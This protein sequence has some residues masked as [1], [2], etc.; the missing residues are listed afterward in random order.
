MSN[1]KALV[2]FSGG[3]DSLLAARVLQEQGITVHAI[4]FRSNFF[5]EN[6]AKKAAE[7]NDIYIRDTVDISKE[8]L[9][10][11]RD[12]NVKKGKNLNPCIDC[13]GLMLRKAKEYVDTDE[14]HFLATGEVLGQRPFSQTKKAMEEVAKKAG[15][16]VLRPLSARRMDPTEIEE[17]GWVDR[18]KLLDIQGR[19]RKEQISW[20]VHYNL[21]E[22]ESPSGGCLLTEEEFSRKLA[23]MTEHFDQVRPEDA[24]LLKKG[25]VEWFNIRNKKGEESPVMAVIGRN[26]EDNVSLYYSQQ[27]GDVLVRLAEMEGPLTLLR[28]KKYN[29]RTKEDTYEVEVQHKLDIKEWKK[30]VY[31]REKEMLEHIALLDAWYKPRVRGDKTTVKVARNI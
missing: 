11:I 2:L 24:E 16:E 29:F 9:G 27:P 6:N 1:I 28:S 18:D 12:D 5:D 17:K 20:T 23:D 14:Y 3:L 19:G 7:A 8:L 26:K 10:L 30:E 13:H 15:V 4:C 21:K 31:S 22:Y 25:R